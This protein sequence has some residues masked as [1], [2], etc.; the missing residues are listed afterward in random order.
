[1]DGQVDHSLPRSSGP[2][3]H[4]KELPL[5]SN[6]S[7]FPPPSS[8]GLPPP[9]SPQPQPPNPAPAA[10]HP[11]PSSNGDAMKDVASPAPPVAPPRPPVTFALRGAGRK[12]SLEAAGEGAGEE[13]DLVRAVKAAKA[14]LSTLP[15]QPPRPPSYR[16]PNA[17]ALAAHAAERERLKAQ[18]LKEREKERERAG[19]T[20]TAAGQ[21]TAAN[22]SAG[23]AHR[24]L[25]GGDISR[26]LTP[27]ELVVY[28]NE[29]E[30]AKMQGRYQVLYAKRQREKDQVQAYKDKGK[31]PPPPPSSASSLL[32]R[33][34]DEELQ[35]NVS[36][37][38]PLGKDASG[39]VDYTSTRFKGGSSI[40]ALMTRDAT[41]A[42]NG[43]PS[44]TS[45]PLQASFVLRLYQHGFSM[46]G[47]DGN[48]LEYTPANLQMLQHLDNGVIP[49]LFT[50][51]SPS[52]SLQFFDGHLICEVRDYRMVQMQ[53]GQKEPKVR[54][55]LLKPTQETVLMDV[56]ATVQEAGIDDPHVEAMVEGEVLKHIRGKLCLWPSPRVFQVLNLAHYNRM[57]GA[58]KRPSR[59]EMEERT[60]DLYDFMGESMFGA[61]PPQLE[62]TEGEEGK[63]VKKEDEKKEVEKKEEVGPIATLLHRLTVL[64]RPV[65]DRLRRLKV[66]ED[67]RRE[68][69]RKEREMR[70]ASIK[71]EGMEDEEATDASRTIKAEDTAMVPR[72]SI[73]SLPSS[74]S[75]F[76]RSTSSASSSSSA[77]SSRFLPFL[78]Y[79]SFTYHT[80]TARHLAASNLLL[81][82]SEA[83][84]RVLSG[85]GRQ[86]ADAQR[87][88]QLALAEYKKSQATGDTSASP[89]QYKKPF[90]IASKFDTSPL[91]DAAT[92]LRNPNETPTDEWTT[93]SFSAPVQHA[94]G[95]RLSM[96]VEVFV[97]A[98][99]GAGPKDKPPSV[100]PPTG[101]PPPAAPVVMSGLYEV[102]VRWST[103][104]AGE[105]LGPPTCVS[106]GTR[107]EMRSFVKEFAR[108]ILRE[109]GRQLN[110]EA[111]VL[112]EPP[113]RLQ[114]D[115][116]LHEMEERAQ[117]MQLLDEHLKAQKRAAATQGPP[118]AP[119]STTGPP[120]PMNGQMGRRLPAGKQPMA[121]GQPPSSLGLPVGY[122]GAQPQP[123][124]REEGPAGGGRMPAGYSYP[125]GVGGMRPAGGEGGG[126]P[127]P[128]HSSSPPPLSHG[129][130]TPPMVFPPPAVPPPYHPHPQQHGHGASSRS[131][132]GHGGYAG[133]GGGGGGQAPPGGPQPPMGQLTPEQMRARDQHRALQQQRYQQQQ[134]QL[135]RQ[136]GGGGGGQGG[137]GQGQP[138]SSLAPPAGSLSPRAASYGRTSTSPQPPMS[139]PAPVS[140]N[141]GYRGGPGGP[142][143][144]G[145]G[146]QGHTPMTPQQFAEYQQRKMMMQQQMQRERGGGGGGGVGNGQGGGGGGGGMDSR[147]PRMMQ[148]QGGQGQS[149]GGG[150]GYGGGQGGQSRYSQE[151][152]MQM[153]EQQQLQQSSRSQPQQQQ[154]GQYPPPPMTHSP[155]PA[156]MMHPQYADQQRR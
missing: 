79:S 117:R 115:N 60:L 78:A 42:A 112:K 4:I 120:P 142:G 155:N 1:M 33:L 70:A 135:M 154:G 74:S 150:G 21:S 92:R 24:V 10:S 9:T 61:D 148:G 87:A 129:A 75:P 121:P 138:Q 2:P 55:L 103:A 58:T 109:G 26:L 40:D 31:T 130:A 151:Q 153:R 39:R 76:S 65:R 37:H 63:G 34:A 132:P 62:E 52:L 29:N 97:H 147:D 108:C 41:A 48:W 14:H 107:D 118:A 102:Y 54:R 72:R 88:Y 18:Y 100:P 82:D 134:Q 122:P 86:V 32:T 85:P 67:E 69:A 145:Q 30:R 83:R 13:G 7:S 114:P 11:T 149:H 156:P 16:P 53:F 64:P 56:R 126:H 71:E 35:L 125:V 127:S 81:L 15:S 12:R 133:G 113:L 144:T 137:Y 111:V 36:H 49:P 106:T 123:A 17:A 105:G 80:S 152:L 143:G 59:E 25:T 99:P 128:P 51:L 91:T 47:D 43:Q 136:Q 90:T 124:R 119:P 131:L 89:P 22:D 95:Q 104:G 93:W 98:V 19:S 23:R 8:N 38:F 116:V 44:S 46:G 27:S 94:Q 68:R 110:K 101:P 20:S 66:K 139:G 73:S 3:P 141:P 77:A 146:G 84:D 45:T 5:P 6:G 28:W 50:S 140:P 96:L 57:K